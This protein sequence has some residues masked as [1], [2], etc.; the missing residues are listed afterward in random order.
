MVNLK[1]ISRQLS[2]MSED[3]MEKNIT[4]DDIREGLN[5]MGFQ[6]IQK[7]VWIPKDAME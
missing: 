4:K 2:E 7:G 6:E 1:R 3:L 5:H